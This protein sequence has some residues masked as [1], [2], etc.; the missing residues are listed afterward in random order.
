MAAPTEL[1]CKALKRVGRYFAGKPRL[2]YM[3]PKQ[4]V[5]H[6]DIYVD[7]DWA[8][9][10]RTRRSTSGGSIMVGKHL[11]KHWSSTQ[12]S[13]SLSSGEAEF[14]GLVRGA[15]HGLGYQSFLKDFDIELPLRMWTDSNPTIGICSMLDP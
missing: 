10:S 8:G 6:V 1:S 5:D 2:V 3:Y 15:G 12:P 7:T 4:K 14:Y 9:C 13:P 11:I